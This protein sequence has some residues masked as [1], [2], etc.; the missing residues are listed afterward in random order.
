VAAQIYTIMRIILKMTL[1][2][3][4]EIVWTGFSWHRIETSGEFL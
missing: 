1:K 4:E 3:S 2:K